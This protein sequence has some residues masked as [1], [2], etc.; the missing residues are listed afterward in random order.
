MRDDGYVP[1]ICAFARPLESDLQH[2][3]D[4]VSG[5]ACWLFCLGCIGRLV[6]WLVCRA[7]LPGPL[8]C[9][10]ASAGV[11]LRSQPCSLIRCPLDTHSLCLQVK[12][13]RYPRVNF[14]IATSGQPPC[15]TKLRCGSLG[16][17]LAEPRCLARPK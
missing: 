5:G 6:G 9:W 11:R 10:L 8:Q 1:A 13:A 2:A 7:R 15:A 16:S 14:F 4:A 12:F 17:L 3:W